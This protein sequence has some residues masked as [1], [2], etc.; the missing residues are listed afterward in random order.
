MSL[1]SSVLLI[2]IDLGTGFGGRGVTAS[3]ALFHNALTLKRTRVL[4]AIA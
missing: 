3:G 2:A 1:R 4:S